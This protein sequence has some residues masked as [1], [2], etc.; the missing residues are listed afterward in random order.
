MW[1]SLWLFCILCI[2]VLN[3]TTYWLQKS[4]NYLDEFHSWT[5]VELSCC[6]TTGEIRQWRPLPLTVRCWHGRTPVLAWIQWPGTVQELC[7]VLPLDWLSNRSCLQVC[8]SWD[9]QELT[10]SLSI[11]HLD[12]RVLPGD[13]IFALSCCL[14][15]RLCVSGIGL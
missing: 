4:T 11:Q 3:Y 14:C 9:N 8:V 10:V 13:W 15:K 7:R 12:D 1:Y 2:F 5:R 6:C